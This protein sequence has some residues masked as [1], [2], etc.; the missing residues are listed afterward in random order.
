MN[1]K[2]LAGVFPYLVS[3]VGTDGKVKEK[4]LVDGRRD[5]GSKATCRCHQAAT[6]FIHRSAVSEEELRLNN[7]LKMP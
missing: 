7:Y 2:E 4:V 5:V 6:S 3:P 1:K